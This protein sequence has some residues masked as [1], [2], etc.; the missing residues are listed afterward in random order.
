MKEVT[1]ND[2]LDALKA[3]LDP[4]LWQTGD[5]LVEFA[6]RE[7][8]DAF[9]EHPGDGRAALELSVRRLETGSGELQGALVAMRRLLNP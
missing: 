2:A 4:L 1:L 7:V 5:G 6:Q 3:G 9:A 8:T